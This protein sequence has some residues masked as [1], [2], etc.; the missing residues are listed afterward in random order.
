MPPGAA[1]EAIR[2]EAPEMLGWDVGA[3]L[4]ANVSDWSQ[5]TMITA[6]NWGKKSPDFKVEERPWVTAE[7]RR[8]KNEGMELSKLWNILSAK[9]AQQ[10]G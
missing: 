4:L 6:G 9:A 1:C 7:K 8:K 5:A 3:R 2:H 10:G